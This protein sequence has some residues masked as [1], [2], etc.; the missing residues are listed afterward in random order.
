V[1]TYSVARRHVVQESCYDTIDRNE[2]H[3]TGLCHNRNA[4]IKKI[5]E[6][7]I[8]QMLYNPLILSFPLMGWLKVTVPIFLLLPTGIMP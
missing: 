7:F 2:S 4:N 5:I 3:V 6:L 1:E 8:H